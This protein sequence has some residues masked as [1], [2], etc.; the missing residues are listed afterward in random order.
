MDF[1]EF[2]YKSAEI[3]GFQHHCENPNVR[4]DCGVDRFINVS[5]YFFHFEDR[6]GM[7]RQCVFLI[8]CCVCWGLILF[9]LF[10]LVYFIFEKQSFCIC[11]RKLNA[12]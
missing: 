2:Q 10:L 6:R 11:F 5:V 4:S 3:D 12:F 8:V 9:Y 1:N 7:N